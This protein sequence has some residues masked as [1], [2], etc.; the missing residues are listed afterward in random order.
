MYFEFFTIMRIAIITDIHE[1]VISLQNAFRKIEKAKCDEIVCLGD[2]SGFSHH[3]HFHSSRNA[4][5]C[6]RLV[7]S[8]CQHIILGNHDIH[9][10]KIIPE[11]CTFFNYPKNWYELDYH[12]RQERAGHILWL[13]EEDDLDPL[14]KQS[15]IEY[16]RYLPQYTVLKLNGYN[17]LF[18]HYI[19][20]NIS[21]LKRE[22]YTYGN[23]FNQ[24]F[25]FMESLECTYSFTGHSH[26]KGFFTATRNKY[27][28]YKY[29]AAEVKKE[30]ICIGIPPI[31]NQRNRSGFCIFDSKDM[32]VQVVKV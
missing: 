23:E 17:V 7:R 27:R 25:D 3:Y 32:L 18:S 28:E 31:S 21:G 20:P 2:I 29:K 6:L 30:P 12:D 10:A 14:Y 9:A 24:H 11:N 8:N 26:T 22:F 5:E 4:H 19:F 15:D 13:H 1:D 16:L